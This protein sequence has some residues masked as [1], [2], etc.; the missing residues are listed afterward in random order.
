MTVSSTL[1]LFL[2]VSTILYFLLLSPRRSIQGFSCLYFIWFHLLLYKAN[3]GNCFQDL[4]MLV[5]FFKIE[6]FVVVIV[7]SLSHSNSL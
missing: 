2:H 3:D 6:I 7:Q 1:P 4:M 5:L